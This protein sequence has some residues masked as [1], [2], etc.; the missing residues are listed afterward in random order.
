MTSS[1]L[2]GSIQI[3][4]FPG[5][6]YMKERDREE[7]GTGMYRRNKKPLPLPTTFVQG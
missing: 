5:P 7:R 6:W 1:S 2:A 4:E 3:S